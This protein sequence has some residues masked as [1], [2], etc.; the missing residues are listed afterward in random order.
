M[1]LSS[2]FTLFGCYCD[3]LNRTYAE[4]LSLIDLKS[5]IIV[6]NLCFEKF[7]V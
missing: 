6:T 5:R 4:L 2:G 3:S 1:V 7:Y